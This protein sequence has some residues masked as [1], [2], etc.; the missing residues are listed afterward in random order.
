MTRHLATLGL[1][2]H[3]LH[4][5]GLRFWLR[6]GGFLEE[7]RLLMPRLKGAYIYQPNPKPQTLNS[8]RVEG[9]TKTP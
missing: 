8:F 7:G 9:W 2:H 3:G 4:I 1:F 6:G 5:G